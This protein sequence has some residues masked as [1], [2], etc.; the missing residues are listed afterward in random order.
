MAIL[1][2][3]VRDDLRFQS[4]FVILD[5]ATYK[6][7]FEWN[8]R[9]EAFSFTISDID[10]VPILSGRELAADSNLL[11]GVPSTS[12]PPGLLILSDTEGRGT[13]PR[14]GELGSIYE[15]LYFEAETVA[16]L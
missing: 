4:F 13:G 8:I 16:T 7:D 3:P 2:L 12:K 10:E 1:K 15:L 9:S 11:S 14:L 6:L 5:G